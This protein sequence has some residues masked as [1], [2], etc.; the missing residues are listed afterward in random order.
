MARLR[1]FNGNPLVGRGRITGRQLV[2][3]GVGHEDVGMYQCFAQVEGQ[4]MQDSAQLE[5][6]GEQHMGRCLK[7]FNIQEYI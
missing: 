1:Y 4:V 3:S 6:A 2:V 5:L 7:L